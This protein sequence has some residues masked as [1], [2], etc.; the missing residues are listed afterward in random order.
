MYN[1]K[2]RTGWVSSLRNDEYPMLVNQLCDIMDVYDLED[3]QVVNALARVKSHLEPLQLVKVRS[4][5]HALTPVLRE[6]QHK[7]SQSLMSLRGHVKAYL[8]STVAGENEAAKVLSLWLDK[9]GMRLLNAG[10]NP[11]TR[12]INELLQEAETDEAVLNAVTVLSLQPLLDSLRDLNDAFNAKFMKR[13]ADK[14]QR[15]SV[16]CRA[17]RNASLEDVRLLLSVLETKVALEGGVYILPFEAIKEL[18]DFYQTSL[19]IRKGRSAADEEEKGKEKESD[20]DSPAE[21]QTL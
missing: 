11:Q 6:L 19:A 18:F 9:H 15:V 13:N 7:R 17:I 4:R 14:S 12:R 2:I 8:R 21:S 16:D 5:S 20:V 1:L 3:Q 10:Y